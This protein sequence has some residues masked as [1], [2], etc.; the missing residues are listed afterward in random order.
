MPNPV[1]ASDERGRTPPDLRRIYDEYFGYVWKL[2]QRFGVPDRHIEDVVHDVFVVV[3]KQ[4]AQYDSSRPIK[5]WLAGI[6][7]RCASDFM[8]RAPQRREVPS[9]DDMDMEV[10]SA[11]PEASAQAKQAHTL[12]HKALGSID[13]SRRS[14]FILHEFEQTPIP[15][16]AEAL[17]IP[18]NTAYSRLRLARA[19]FEAAVRMLTTGGSA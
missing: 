16:I 15:E 7:F 12:V 8:R 4:L 3:H 5:P 19:D 13:E 14:V 10:S 2:A 11:N 1:H 9:S 6:A 17:S 18:V